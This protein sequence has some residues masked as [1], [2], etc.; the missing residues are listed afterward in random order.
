[1]SRTSSLLDLAA[2]L[3]ILGQPVKALETEQAR[4]AALGATELNQL[5]HAFVPWEQGVLVL[6]GDEATILPQLEGLGLPAP[7]RASPSGELLPQR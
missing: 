4:I 7:L 6:V 3:H 5:A 2:D 1:V